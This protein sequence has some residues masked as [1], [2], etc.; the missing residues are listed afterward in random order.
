MCSVPTGLSVKP[1]GPLRVRC[2]QEPHAARGIIPSTHNPACHQPAGRTLSLRIP[3][4]KSNAVG[5]KGPAEKGQEAD[6]SPGAG[7]QRQAEAR[8]E[9]GPAG[10]LHA[11]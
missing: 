6:A 9:A 11:A 5:V 4:R 1:L 2:S 10:R 7:E 3:G 8:A